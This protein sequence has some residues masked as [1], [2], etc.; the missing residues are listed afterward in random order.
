MNFC[1]KQHNYSP[2]GRLKLYIMEAVDVRPHS[3]FEQPLKASSRFSAM[4]GTKGCM[5]GSLYTWCWSPGTERIECKLSKGRAFEDNVQ[6]EKL[7]LLPPFQKPVL[8]G[9][10]E[11]FWEI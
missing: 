10:L 2:F 9:L 8:C 11:T 4:R 5:S 7:F 6:S 3:F 1:H